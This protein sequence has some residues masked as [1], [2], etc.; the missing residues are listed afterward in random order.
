MTC[1]CLCTEPETY[2]LLVSVENSGARLSA[3]ESIREPEA[4][5]T[6]LALGQD[7]FG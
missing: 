1:P 2:H 7:G 3:H 4:Y 5:G 6:K